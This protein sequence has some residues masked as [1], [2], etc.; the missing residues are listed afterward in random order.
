[1]TLI[2][3]LEYGAEVSWA[4][5]NPSP[6]ITFMYAGEKPPEIVQ[7]SVLVVQTRECETFIYDGTRE[8]YGWSGSEWLL[9]PREFTRYLEDM[10]S[11]WEDGA[12]LLKLTRRVLSRGEEGYWGRIFTTFE[13]MWKDLRWNAMKGMDPQL[14]EKVVREAAEKRAEGAARATWGWKPHR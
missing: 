2:W 3:A 12:S 14:V 1:V 7:H 6:D 13:C 10:R 11:E 5:V 9:E 4:L 8:Q